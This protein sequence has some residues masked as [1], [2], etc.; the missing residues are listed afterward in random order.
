M[1]GTVVVTVACLAAVLVAIRRFV[2]LR[3]GGQLPHLLSAALLCFGLGKLART[4]VVSDEWI[5][6]WFHS[7]TG[8]WN[9]SDF[10]GMS[11]GVT[12]AQFMMFGVGAILGKPA[13]KWAL[14][15]SIAVVWA[16]L[17]ITFA[18][19]PVPHE[20][21]SFMSQDFAMTGW[22]ALYWAFY[23][24]GLGIPMATIGLLSARAAKVFQPGTARKA[25]LATAACGLGGSLYVLH[26][27]VNLTVERF[28]VFRWYADNAPTISLSILTCMLVLSS[29]AL[30]LVP[31]ASTRRRLRRYTLL[32]DRIA[33]WRAM[34]ADNPEIALDPSLMPE[35]R[36]AL[37]E[38][39]A[40]AVATNRMM[41]ELADSATQPA[42]TSSPA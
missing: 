33:D 31:L 4:P 30:I 10:V 20:P 24:L 23:L 38:A 15:A 2:V 26:K 12:G 25:A 37:W 6:G 34:H 1:I 42:P 36:W 29:A 11:L 14:P 41:V 9:V 27:L 39:T 35:G 13:P 22:F 19:S 18:L 32:R 17:G 7:L 8:I 3:D 16:E 28:G 40:D 21:T 5:D